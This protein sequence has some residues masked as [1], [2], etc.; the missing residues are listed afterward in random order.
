MEGSSKPSWYIK[1]VYSSNN[2]PLHLSPIKTDN[3]L[4]ST[5]LLLPKFP[6]LIDLDLNERSFARE[7]QSPEYSMT[8]HD[9]HLESKNMDFNNMQNFPSTPMNN[10]ERST[11]MLLTPEISELSND[12]EEFD[13]LME[14]RFLQLPRH[15]ST[16]TFDEFIHPESIDILPSKPDDVPAQK[17]FWS[18]KFKTGLFNTIESK[19]S[20]FAQN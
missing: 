6:S 5:P 15:E 18:I 10:T 14:P 13:G 20:P 2:S 16:H 1:S 17:N 7:F 11:L 8:F 9:F 19:N 3:N 4:L 12:I